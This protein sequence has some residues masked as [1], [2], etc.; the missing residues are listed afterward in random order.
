VGRPREH[1]E[2][3]RLVLLDAAEAL[4]GRGGL[5]AVS[6]RAVADSAGT[7]VRAVYSLFGSKEGLVRALAQRAF[8]LLMARVD[9]TGTTADPAADLASAALHGFRPFA[10]DHPDLFRVAFVWGGVDLGPDVGEA[11][12]RAFG[13]LAARIE[14]ARAAGLVPDRPVEELGCE[15]HALCQGLASL[16]LCASMTGAQADR[17]WAHSVGDLMAGLRA[18]AAAESAVAADATGGS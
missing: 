14:R 13:R 6:V 16:E 17:L 18:R 10:L 3:T 11:S 9:S 4:V 12:A 1:D 2:G 8:E 5:E 15:F 7:S